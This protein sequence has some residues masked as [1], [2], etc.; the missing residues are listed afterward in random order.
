MKVLID[1]G[2]QIHVGTGIGNY[3]LFLYKE[4][5]KRNG[6]TA[7]LSDYAVKNTSRGLRRLQY[8]IYINSSEFLRKT[9]EYDVVHFTNYA[10]PFRRAK[11][12]KYVVTIHDL[13][14]F[15]Y[16][17]SLPF[18]YR[19]YSKYIIQ[20][21]IKKADI[22]LTVSESVKNE[23]IDRWPFS[24]EKVCVAYPGFYYKNKE[25]D[26]QMDYVNNNLKRLEERFFLFVGTIEKRKNLSIVLQAFSVILKENPNV[27]LVLAGRVGFGFDE[28]VNLIKKL[29]ISSNVIITGYLEDEDIAK[30][31]SETCAYIFPS[32]YEGFGSTQLECMFYHT[33][34]ILGEIPTNKEVSTE[35]GL[36]FDLD[37]VN[38][39]VFRMR[40]ILDNNY[41]QAEHNKIAD[42]IIEK[43]M[44]E[45]VIE[46]YI[47]AYS[48]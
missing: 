29:Q 5:N 31:Y 24:E 28:Y 7:E 14:S 23:I 3:S 8:L 36:F 45:N 25:I 35:Y 43:Y 22:I 6:I 34:L 27:K 21:A 2:M 12:T 18:V 39:L 16:S 1:D 32:V 30:L 38:S 33:P 37:N 17:E 42:Q 4:L 40:E 9:Q 13:A 11:N 10:M 47:E 19:Q 26:M 41:D 15:I 20:Y 48:K 46:D 44:W